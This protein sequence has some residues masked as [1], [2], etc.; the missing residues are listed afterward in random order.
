MMTLKEETVTRGKEV[1][2]M[3]VGLVRTYSSH[4][5]ICA[6]SILYLMHV[7]YIQT[8]WLF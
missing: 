1:V 7:S 5:I 8:K 6:F 2:V 3:R 4:H